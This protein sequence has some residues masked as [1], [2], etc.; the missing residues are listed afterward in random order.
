MIPYSFFSLALM[1]IY[2]LGGIQP[3][4]SY[5]WS[6]LDAKLTPGALIMPTV[7]DW[8]SQCVDIEFSVYGT[9][10]LSNLLE[11]PAG[12]CLAHASC[13]FEKC[14]PDV[15]KWEDFVTYLALF[16]FLSSSWNFRLMEK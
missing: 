8:Y 4:Y 5:P 10:N 12:L 6:D 2:V 7:D 3:I 1:V 9:G 13:S 14:I 15:Y 16:F 11:E